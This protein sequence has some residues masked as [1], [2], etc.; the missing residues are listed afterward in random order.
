MMAFVQ[1]NQQ[2][3]EAGMSQRLS[4]ARKHPITGEEIAPL[5]FD[6]NGI[7]FFPIMGAAPDGDDDDDDTDDGDD[8]G[9][10]DSGNDGSEGQDGSGD[11]SKV[12][13]EEFARLEARMKAADKRAAAA[14]K[15]AKEY[16]DKDKDE[17]TKLA[18]RA[19]AAETEAKEIREERNTLRLQKA[20]LLA[21]D[22]A[23]HDAEV[24]LQH[25]DLSEVTD[26]EGNI[27]RKAL[28]KALEDL[29]KSKP[30]LV[31]SKD[32]SDDDKDE[33]SG[34]TGVRTAGSGKKTKKE[35]SSDDVLRQKYPALYV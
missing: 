35:V 20:F 27:D 18:E 33:P 4:T 34:P 11:G 9:D 19:A 13:P 32:D 14:E 1:A 6:Q 24:A 2:T 31:K 5:W 7:A 10:D 29:S 22:I 28:K 26:E 23:W 21:N 17:A 15:K 12:T 25:A 8:D 3:T 16:E 30:F